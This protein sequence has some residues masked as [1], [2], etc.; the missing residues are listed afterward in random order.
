MNTDRPTTWTQPNPDHWDGWE[1]CTG[2]GWQT[3]RM[4]VWPRN[5][6]GRWTYCVDAVRGATV[7]RIF[8]PWEREGG[9]GEAEPTFPTRELAQAAAEEWVR[10]WARGLL[11]AVGP[12]EL[13]EKPEQLE[14]TP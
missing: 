5:Y 14:P 2:T 9:C 1:R 6:D 3:T 11:R 7:G 8:D 4:M 12:G 13:L 10:K